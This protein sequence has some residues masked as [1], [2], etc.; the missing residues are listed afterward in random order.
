MSIVLGEDRVGGS[1]AMCGRVGRH[2]RKGCEAG[3]LSLDVR[4]KGQV[5]GRGNF[6]VSPDV[7]LATKRLKKGSCSTMDSCTKKGGVRVRR[8]KV[9]DM[10]KEVKLK[11]K[12]RAREDG[13]FT[14]VTLTRRFKKGIGDVF[15]TRGR[16]A[17]K[18]RMSL[19]SD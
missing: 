1:C 8:S 15:D 16:P 7:R 17:D 14:G 11:V 12:G 2:L 10:V 5:G 13:L 9:G 6:C 4:C 18:A 19:G 3:N